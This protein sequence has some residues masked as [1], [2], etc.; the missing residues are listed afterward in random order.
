MKITGS[1][2]HSHNIGTPPQ[3][4]YYLQNSIS[5]NDILSKPPPKNPRRNEGAMMGSSM[6]SNAD[7][8]YQEQNV[9]NRSQADAEANRVASP[10]I[11][12]IGTVF[13]HKI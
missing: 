8:R 2:N 11:R 9:H 5:V 3:N 13:K 12:S 10:L 1:N 6:R 7:G 4:N